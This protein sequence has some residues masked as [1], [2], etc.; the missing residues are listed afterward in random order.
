MAIR[1]FARDDDQADDLLQDCW[2]HILER[3]HQFRGRGSFTA[4]AIAVS[5][6]VCRM[7]LRHESREG[8]LKVAVEAAEHLVSRDL[9]LT[10]QEDL[11]TTAESLQKLRQQA[12]SRALGRL[13][14][15]ERDAIVL[16]LLEGRDTAETAQILKMS[17]AGVR[18][19][20]LRGMT[21]LKKMKEMRELLPEW[22]GWN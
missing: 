10:D 19:I 4:W 22:M 20:L 9:D 18:S 12:V 15:R 8:V 3:L 1:H 7:H 2:V 5:K 16:R 14:D 13:P 11:P 17:E 6:N 21:R